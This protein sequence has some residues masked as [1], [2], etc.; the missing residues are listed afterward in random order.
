LLHLTV[1]ALPWGVF[2]T[3]P[4][5]ILSPSWVLLHSDKRTPFAADLELHS[6]AHSLAFDHFVKAAFKLGFQKLPVLFSCF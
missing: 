2:E 4:R 3:L 1:G 5:L 6:Q